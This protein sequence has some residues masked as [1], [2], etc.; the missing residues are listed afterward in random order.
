LSID[1][2]AGVLLVALPIAF[3]VFFFLLGRRFD[4]PS[5]LRQ[6]VGTILGRFHAGGAEL[7]LLW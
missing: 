2:V 3:N 6:P 4:Y 1:R 7:R 5:V